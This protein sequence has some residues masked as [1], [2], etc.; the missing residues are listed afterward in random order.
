M[1]AA[2]FNKM[3]EEKGLSHRA[4]SCGVC[5]VT[6]LPASENSLIA[7]E[8]LG[9]DL[10][11]F[12]STALD[13]ITLS[14]YELIVCMTESHKEALLN[15]GVP[16]EKVLVLAQDRGGI[17][18][19][20]GGNLGRYIICRDEMILSLEELFSRFCIS[21][22]VSLRKLNCD[23]GKSVHDLA[24]AS[25]SAPW[26]QE[27]IDAMLKRENA[28]LLGG[29]LG[30]K[31]VGFTA[32]EWVLDE[33][34]LTEI[35]VLKECRGQ[36]IAN[37]LMSELIKTAQEKNLAFITL[38]VRESNI[39]AISLYKKFGFR[40]VGVRKNYYKNPTE[41]ALLMTRENLS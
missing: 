10:S 6:G 4:D 38:E 33:G 25:F 39:P 32:L 12:R 2:L 31:L 40:E 24:T 26:S 16:E 9:L 20:Y 8:Q 28:L 13:D 34:S 14:D 27:T 29:F 41:N 22:S 30:D 35:A 5:T 23:D 19:P 37:M 1:A 15:F 11:S 7:C 21:D 17:S 3:A 18:D 36:G